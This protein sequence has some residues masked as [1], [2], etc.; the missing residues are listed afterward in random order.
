MRVL[1]FLTITAF[2]AV[3][4]VDAAAADR[5][6]E[7][8]F[9]T[10]SGFGHAE[11]SK[12]SFIKTERNFGLVIQPWG[13]DGF[14]V[15]WATGKRKGTDPN[16]LE[17]VISRHLSRFRPAGTP[18]VY[19]AAGNGGVLEGKPT[20]WARM[21]GDALIV[22]LLEVGSDGIPELQI[23]RRTLTTKG[24]ELLFTSTRDGEL[25]R[26]VRGRYK[27]EQ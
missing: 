17:G 18:G 23:Y 7:R 9:G 26:T 27:R 11:D 2:L 19:A 5:E 20:S 25:K 16:R 21:R 4:A 1:Q 13:A 10:Y 24:L 14:E 8:F 3:A 6:L 12:G 15:S 22:Y